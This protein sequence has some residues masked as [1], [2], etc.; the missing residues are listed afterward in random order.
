MYCNITAN[1]TDTDQQ[2]NTSYKP[3]GRYTKVNGKLQEY[4][5][6]IDFVDMADILDPLQILNLMIFFFQLNT[7]ER[8]GYHRV[9]RKSILQLGHGQMQSNKN[10]VNLKLLKLK[11]FFSLYLYSF[12]CSTRHLWSCWRARPGIQRHIQQLW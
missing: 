8:L 9:K 12:R 2:D 6:A 11:Q 7:M 4:I 3:L 1:H 10:C 5:R